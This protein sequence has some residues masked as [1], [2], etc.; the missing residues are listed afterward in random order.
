MADETVD[1]GDEKQVKTRKT[2]MQ[3]RRE[4]EV[5]NLRAILKTAGGRAFIWLLLEQC[6]I[7]Q[8]AAGDPYE[9]ARGEGKR[10]I[11][12]WAMNEV[13]TSD[14]QAYTIMRNEAVSRDTKKKGK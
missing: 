10:D 2:A 5:E 6:G 4:N 9:V 7:Y 14:P 1:V 3:L 11:G 8:S 13:F 12:L